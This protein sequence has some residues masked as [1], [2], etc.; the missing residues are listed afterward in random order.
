MKTDKICG[1]ISI[2]VVIGLFCGVII[3]LIL[4]YGG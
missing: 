4:V 3:T 1:Y 2:G